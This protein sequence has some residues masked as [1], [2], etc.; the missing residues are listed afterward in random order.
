MSQVNIFI[1]KTALVIFSII[2]FFTQTQPIQ[3]VCTGITT[4]HYYGNCHWSKRPATSCDRS[5]KDTPDPPD[6]IYGTCTCDSLTGT[7]APCSNCGIANGCYPFCGTVGTPFDTGPA[8]ETVTT[9]CQNIYCGDGI[10]NGSENSDNCPSDCQTAGVC[11]DGNCDASIGETKITCPSDCGTGSY[12]ACG[13]CECGHPDQCR[14]DPNGVCIWDGG[15]PVK[16]GPSCSYDI[17]QREYPACRKAENTCICAEKNICTAGIGTCCTSCADADP[18][19]VGSGCLCACGPKGEN[20]GKP[21]LVT[22]T[23]PAGG[24]ATFDVATGQVAIVWD[25]EENGKAEKYRYEL[26][27]QGSTDPLCVNDNYAVCGNQKANLRN[28]R[29]YPNI[30]GGNAY[31]VRVR[32]INTDCDKTIYGDWSTVNFVIVAS[33]KTK[34]FLDDTAAAQTQGD[35]CQLVGATPTPVVPGTGKKGYRG[36]LQV[37]GNVPPIYASNITATT[38]NM[39]VPYWPDPRG[40]YKVTYA[41]GK[42]SAGTFYN[43]TCPQ[44]CFYAG[45]DSP[46]EGINFFVT[47]NEVNTVDT[48]HAGWWQAVG[49]NVQAMS[50]GGTA[51]LDPIPVATCT[52]AEDCVPAMSKKDLTDTEDSAGIAIT[53]GGTIDSSDEQGSSQGY[54]TD[55][56][57]QAFAVGTAPKTRENYDYFYRLYSLGNNPTTSPDFAGSADDASKPSTTLDGQRAYFNEGN[58][59]IQRRW[60]VVDGEKLVIFVHGDLIIDDPSGAGNLI[61][62]QPGGFLS[63]I[64]SGNI[65]IKNTVGNADPASTNTNI[66]GVYIADGTLTVETKTAAGGGD[67]HFVGAGT[68]VGWGGVDLQRDYSDGGDRKAENNTQPTETF[69]FRPD[70]IQNLPER[71]KKPVYVWQETN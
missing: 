54:I 52:T 4:C 71:M 14:T 66:E 33:I 13:S 53:G 20:E 26:F 28:F 41:P 25:R 30:N 35:M 56:A 49:G 18:P 2:L 9:S 58:L 46:Q 29:F 17:N 22:F 63:F 34:F 12:G 38:K 42:N 11:G 67:N 59:T 3:A 50:S 6:P 64:V 5:K 51:L 31:T 19:L 48:T 37:E 23:S 47:T 39:T 44:G 70:F 1:I 32:G 27:K 15:C 62:V 57:S 16:G 24:K 65:L 10:C 21:G 60:S 8:C 45:I 69:I 40:A 7:S 68:F 55:R 36:Q 43:C 61:E